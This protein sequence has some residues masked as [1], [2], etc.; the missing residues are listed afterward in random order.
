MGIEITREL[1][2]QCL[3]EAVS[4]YL[5]QEIHSGCSTAR[6]FRLWK[7][8]G[9]CLYLKT[10]HHA[11]DR[12]LLQEKLRL[13]WLQGHLP[14]PRVEMF[15]EDNNCDYL[16]LSAIPGTIA[17]DDAY[18]TN[19]PKLIEQL[20]AGLRTIHELPID[21]CPFD[22]TTHTK[23]ELARE[24]VVNGLVDESDFDE[25][26]LGRTAVD[27]FDELLDAVADGEELVFT[28]GD[29]CL[30]NIVLQDWKISGF[31]DWGRAGVADRYQDIALM[32]RSIESNFGS[33]WVSVLFEACSIEPDHAK[34]R[35]Y[36]LLDEFF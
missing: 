22:A 18:K 3:A 34:V 15:V 20:S 26:R 7:S 30:P 33:E 6:V 23:I 19:V 28:H 36:T 16:L 2:P 4:D 27:L 5:L 17:S 24:R 25:S 35:F 1:L 12:H 32:A 21:R 14:V 9:S 13:E 11:P 10:A 8:G 31:I 29:Y